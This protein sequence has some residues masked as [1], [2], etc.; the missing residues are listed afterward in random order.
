MNACIL[1]VLVLGT[2]LL[3]GTVL[4][5]CVKTGDVLV[6]QPLAQK[7]P[8][9]GTVGVV[10]NA[11]P[12]WS[13]DADRMKEGLFHQLAESGWKHADSPDYVFEVTFVSFDKG[14]GAARAFN[15]GGEAE[16]YAHVE[17]K[18]R[19]GQRLAKLA[20]T[21]NSKRKST[22]S[23]GG[24][25]TAWGDNLPARAVSAAIDQIIEYLQA[26]A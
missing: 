8:H 11:K 12:E 6:E 23:V 16:L 4:T 13:V 17:V 20:V 1:R 18:T 25:N 21:G 19:E 3:G 5:G 24:Y 15:V 2:A 22:V 14:S 10:V 26:H 7:L 9:T